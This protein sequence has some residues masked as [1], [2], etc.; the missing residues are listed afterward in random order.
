[1]SL[2]DKE[3]LRGKWIYYNIF[4]K[5]HPKKIKLSRKNPFKDFS[6]ILVKCPLVCQSLAESLKRQ[7]EGLKKD[8]AR[9]V[10]FLGYILKVLNLFLKQ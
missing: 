2:F 6:N 9:I 4:Q 5:N 1:M 8:S 7:P 3:R 10:K